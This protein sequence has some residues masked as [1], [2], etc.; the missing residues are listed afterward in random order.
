M[1]ICTPHIYQNTEVYKFN[2]YEEYIVKCTEF[3]NMGR[4]YT[5]TN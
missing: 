1:S 4:P 5:P 3:N 2:T